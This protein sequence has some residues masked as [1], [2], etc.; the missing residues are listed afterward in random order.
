MSSLLN[1]ALKQDE[2]S[3][4]RLNK[5][6]GRPL[7]HA[8]HFVQSKKGVGGG[9]SPCGGVYGEV[10]AKKTKRLNGFAGG[11]ACVPCLEV[12]GG[13]EGGGIAKGVS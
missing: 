4:K 10:N 8:S 6:G 11:L 9:R 7:L 13:G 12:S 1:L 3:W 5:K 2:R